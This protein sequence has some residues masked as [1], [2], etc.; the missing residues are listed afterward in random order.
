LK[1]A[2]LENSFEPSVVQYVIDLY[3]EGVT[4]ANHI[5]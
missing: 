2:K 1:Y 5:F 4:N 3:S